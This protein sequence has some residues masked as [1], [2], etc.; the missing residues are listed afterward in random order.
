MLC[1]KIRIAVIYGDD[2][3]LLFARLSN[4]E[5]LPAFECC[6]IY[7]TIVYSS[8]YVPILLFDSQCDSRFVRIVHDLVCLTIVKDDLDRLHSIHPIHYNLTIIRVSLH[9]GIKTIQVKRQ[10]DVATNS[11]SRHEDL[12]PSCVRQVQV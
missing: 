5:A 9:A 11:Q 4:N 7:F 10:C 3:V 6:S 1:C 8:L 12:S 2:H